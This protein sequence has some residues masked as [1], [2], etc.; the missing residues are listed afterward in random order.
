M[1][2][3]LE[4]ELVSTLCFCHKLCR[5]FIFYCQDWLPQPAWALQCHP[6][7]LGSLSNV[8]L[9]YY[10][11]GMWI[12]ALCFEDGHWLGTPPSALQK[13]QR[14]LFLQEQIDKEVELGYYSDS[15]SPDLLPGMYSMPIHGVPKPGSKT[16]YWSV[17]PQQH[18]F[19]WG[20]HWSHPGQCPGLA[21]PFTIFTR[22]T[23]TLIWFSGRLMCLK[24]TDACLCIPYGR[25][26]RWP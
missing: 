5:D 15:F 13:H 10:V 17:C 21:M 12:N 16:Q 26:S 25:S 19:M 4:A 1:W 22:V 20:Y 18:D 6:R 14:R 3:H 24:P 23:L 2:E 7:I 11:S 9:W 8:L